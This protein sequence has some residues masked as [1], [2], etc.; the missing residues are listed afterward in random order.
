VVALGRGRSTRAL[1]SARAGIVASFAGCS[2]VGDRSTSAERWLDGAAGRRKDDHPMTGT[3]TG[4]H[5]GGQSGG[6]GYIAPDALVR[7]WKLIFRQAAVA[8]DGFADLRTGQRVRFDQEP[9]P[10]N[11]GRSHAVR[12]APFD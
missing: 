6:Y 10:G 12:V 1:P 8:A 9:L 7:P 2:Q 4:L 5:A 3:I 11:P